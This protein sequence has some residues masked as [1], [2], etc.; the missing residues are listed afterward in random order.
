ML[1][2]IR[3]AFR[4]LLK[5]PSFSILAI[6]ILALGLGGVTYMFGIIN[7]MVLRPLPFPEPDRLMHIEASNLEQGRDSMEVTQLDYLELRDQQTLL[8]GIAAFYSGTVN[9]SDGS[10]PERYEGGFMSANSF[11]VLGEQ[12]M[13]GRS[14]T[15]DEGQPGAKDV[16]ILGYQI[17]QQRYNADP[18]IVGKTVRAN[19]APSEVIGVMPEGFKFP[20][21]QD[22]WLPLRIDTSEAT[23]N[24]DTLTLEAFARLNDGVT[25][26]QAQQE[27]STIYERL[28]EQF[29]DTNEGIAAVVKPYTHEYIGDGTRRVLATMFGAVFFV[30][31]IASANVANLMLARASR[32]TQEAAVRAAMG[33]GR[34]RLI[35]QMLTETLVIAGIGSLI[36]LLI[37]NVAMK[38]TEDYLITNNMLDVYWVHFTFDARVYLFVLAAVV[39]TTVLAGIMPALRASRPDINGVLRDGT[40]GNTNRAISRT[41]RILVIAEIALSCVLLVGAGLTVRSVMKIG[42]MDVG[43]NID[44]YLSGRIGLFDTDYPEPEQQARFFQEVVDRLNARPEVI[45]ASASIGMPGSFTNWADYYLRGQ[46]E[47]NLPERQFAKQNIVSSEYFENFGI[48][49]QQGRLFDTRDQADSQPVIV[50]DQYFAE[51]VFGQGVD[52]LGKEVRFGTGDDAEWRTVV[53]VVPTVFY[54]D[55]ED[56]PM[57]TVYYPVA[58]EPVRFMFIALRGN[59]D[60]VMSMAPVFRDA[61]AKVDADLPIYWL[62]DARTWLDQA[63]A[64]HILLATMFGAFAIVAILLAAAGIY[65]TMA[66]SVNQR[67]QELGVRRALGAKDSAIMKLI[68][69]QGAKQLAIGL[70]LGLGGA[71]AVARVLSFILVDITPTDPLTFATVTILLAAV[72]MAA[73]FWPARRASQIDPIQALRYE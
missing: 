31:L 30:L 70:V 41:T 9:L 20:L 21:D 62:Q 57:P 37:A 1:Q 22:V 69:G 56:G 53:G 15:Q 39:I 51:N 6:L 8:N 65:G 28:A 32:R 46:D 48:P 10:R 17:W 38:A 5:T 33:A 14:F 11:D 58:Q 29:P 72:V 59:S 63:R 55:V 26:E 50:I 24:G 34:K 7:A 2:D 64:D 25:Q 73:S 13:M 44:G 43:A 3:F 18:N 4:T 36:G 49:V 12:P 45:S 67:T 23:R 60:D 66:Y 27:L 40:R 54:G 71:F 16:V 42:E 47:E 19:G 52:P 35:M 68:T 61:L